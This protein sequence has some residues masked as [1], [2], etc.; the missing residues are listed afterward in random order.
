MGLRSRELSS[1]LP[2]Y[3]EGADSRLRLPQ[4]VRASLLADGSKPFVEIRPCEDSRHFAS[5]GAAT[6]YVCFGAATSRDAHVVR[7]TGFEAN[8]EQAGLPLNHPKLPRG[9]ASSSA[10]MILR[11]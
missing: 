7:E 1:E 2:C 11:P 8:G 3:R 10:T 9:P 5:F 4:L 6:S